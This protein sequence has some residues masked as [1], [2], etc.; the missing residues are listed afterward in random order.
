MDNKIVITQI[1]EFQLMLHEIETEGIILPEIFQVA[2][3][4]E[5]LPPAWRDFKTTKAQAQ[6]ADIGRSHCEVSN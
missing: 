4:V 2:T 1:Q 5:K 6:E 3:I